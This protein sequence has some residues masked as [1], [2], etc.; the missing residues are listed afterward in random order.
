MFDL[1]LANP[2]LEL[3]YMCYD[4]IEIE[5]IEGYMFKAVKGIEITPNEAKIWTSLK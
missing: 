1:W 4:I 5:Y 2:D 3:L